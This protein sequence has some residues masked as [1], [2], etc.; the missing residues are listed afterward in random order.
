MGS[1]ARVN[2]NVQTEQVWCMELL[3]ETMPTV[4][5]Q[6]SHDG[7]ERQSRSCLAPSNSKSQGS[8][9]AACVAAGAG[10]VVGWCGVLRLGRLGQ[11][12]PPTDPF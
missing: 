4:K 11:V 6:G 2:D 1:V 7:D 3:S 9:S 8:Q 12:E 5:P 10:E